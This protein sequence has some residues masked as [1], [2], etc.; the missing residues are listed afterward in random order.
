MEPHELDELVQIKTILCEIR[1]R[2]L[3][4]REGRRQQVLRE[5]DATIRL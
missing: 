1:D 4:E 3:D 5:I 2:Q